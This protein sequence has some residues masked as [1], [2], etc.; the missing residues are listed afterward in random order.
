MRHRRE[1][2][3][4][5]ARQREERDERHRD[6]QRRGEHRRP[7][8]AGGQQDALDL[9]AASRATERCR[10]MFSIM[11]TVESTTI[12]KSTAP[13]E[14]RL[15][16]VPVP[17]IPMKAIMQRQ[18]D[19]ERGDE[20]RAAVAE[21]EP[22]DQRHQHH[23]DQQVLDDGV[24]GQLDQV[25]AVVVGLDVHPRGQDVVSGDLVDLLVDVVE[26]LQRVA[27][28]AHEDGALHDVGIEILADDPQARRV[29]DRDVGD[30]AHAHRRA[31]LLGDD[32]LADVGTA[33]G[34]GRA[35]HVERLLAHAS[36]AARRRSGWRSTSAAISWLSV[37]PCPLQ[38][39]GVDLDVVLLGEA[40]EADDV[41]DARRLAELPLEDPVLR[42]LAG[43][44]ASSPSP[45]TT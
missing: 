15:A 17:T 39:E 28:V 10:K 24:G 19:V 38:P 2:H 3:A 37:R 7:D 41:D 30:V 14:I 13:S 42:R 45:R 34:T 26:R 32:H 5:H 1:D 22:E 44:S 33:S 43:R 18:R 35:A 29:S 11:I 23:P 8:L 16:G 40:A 9:V 27:A 4:R 21:E 12:P 20:R 6:H 25:G 31:V 36:A